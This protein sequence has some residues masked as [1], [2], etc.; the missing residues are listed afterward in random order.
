MDSLRQRLPFKF[1]DN[2]LGISE[3]DTHILDEQGLLTHYA[4]SDST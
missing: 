2:H 1:S 4:F 3:E